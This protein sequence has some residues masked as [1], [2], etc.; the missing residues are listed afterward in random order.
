M[1]KR[2]LTIGYIS[3]FLI[4]DSMAIDILR[5]INQAAKDFDINLIIINIGR[6]YNEEG[7]YEI[8]TKI[9]KKFMTDK[10]FIN[11]HNFDGL[12]FWGTSLHSFLTYSEVPELI[13]SFKDIPCINISGGI[14]GISSIMM[15]NYSGIK[16]ILTHLIEHHGLTKIA[17]LQGDPKHPYSIERFKAYCDVLKEYEIPLNPDLIAP[18]YGWQT[19]A[20]IKACRY[21]F[22]EKKL[23]P[24]KDMEAIV[25]AGD[26]LAVGLMD[27]LRKKKYSVPND[28]ALTGFNNK[29]ESRAM[30]PALTTV[31]SFFTKI[32]YIAVEKL[33]NHIQGGEKLEPIYYVPVE[34][35]IRQ[36][37]GCFNR[38]LVN[39][40]TERETRVSINNI[41][42]I[43]RI[44]NRKEDIFNDI[45][46][47]LKK[48]NYKFNPRDLKKIFYILIDDISRTKPKE[49]IR[50]FEEYIKIKNCIL[51]DLYFLNDVLSFTRKFLIPCINSPV[52]L[53]RLE[54]LLQQ[55]RIMINI[56]MACGMEAM[57]Y[58]YSKKQLDI[59]TLSH[60]LNST[61]DLNKLTEYI[62]MI[63]KILEI[64]G[65][66]IHI[67]PDKRDNY[68]K[69]KQVIY[70][71]KEK[72]YHIK[73]DNISDNILDSILPSK[74]RISLVIKPLF[75]QET[76]LGTII[77]R[78]EKEIDIAL[79]EILR[80]TISVA[81][82]GAI[83]IDERKKMQE[84]RDLLYEEA[85]QANK[86]KSIFLANMSHEIRTP[87]NA[88]LGLN[89]LMGK[90]DLDNTQKEYTNKIKYSAQLLLNH[91]NDLLDFSK[92]EAGK[93][94]IDSGPI[95]LLNTI[96]NL[97]DLMNV[98][99]QEKGLKL[100]TSFS[101]D[102]PETLIGDQ[103]RLEQVLMNLI[104]NA[105]KFTEKGEVNLVV[106]LV[107]RSKTDAKIKFSVMDTGV[108]L[109]EG[110]KKKL[111]K[112]FTQADASTT[113]KFGGT[114]L[115]L[116]ISQSLVKLLGG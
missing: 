40:K 104:N 108:G 63:L 79:L 17:F 29:P 83:I 45:I 66:Y 14:E 50:C 75:F 52:Y 112:P 99:S 33:Y 72:Y 11:R 20:V 61:F 23:K 6:F 3:G 62:K 81:L 16:L 58:D 77:F 44:K 93:L 4:E 30:A 111:F 38:Q 27:V 67:S 107:S 37:C 5:N 13:K 41:P 8:S 18:G 48:F 7:R 10:N 31:D 91:I 113:R 34:L 82:K 25:A 28:I 56:S 49:F 53:H 97:I 57:E 1:N 19:D 59:V 100:N 68:K 2:R 21:F 26:P 85:V 9:H 96:K 71:E 89:Y 32:G 39:S 109:T 87:L 92:I 69:D 65:C 42:C 116:S 80:G 86:A 74:N 105:I 51:S 60:K 54:E 94:T 12:I 24:K 95:N 73:G 76:I 106:S 64:Q 114:G 88:V 15:D 47:E 103:F 22:D 101:E 36:S 55:A 35:V 110:Q 98:K 102:I 43:N 78:T 70:F 46:N 115:G 90:T 84:E